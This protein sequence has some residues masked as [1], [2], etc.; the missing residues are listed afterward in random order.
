MNDNKN[1]LLLRGAFVKNPLLVLFLG[2]CPAMAATTGVIPAVGMGCAVLSVMLLSSLVIALIYRAIPNKVKIPA[3]VLITAAFASV[4][5]LLMNAYFPETYRKLGVYMAVAAIDLVII[6]NAETAAEKGVK[7]S[8]L[9][10][11]IT[12]IAFTLAMFVIATLR[13]IL[14]SGCFAGIELPFFNSFN[15]PLLAK[16]PG[17]FFM[18]AILLAV[19]NK[20]FGKSIKGR[21]FACKASCIPTEEIETQGE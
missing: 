4:V 18:F 17:G 14:G 21:S 3:Y 10:S 12:G 6:N 11:V 19:V 16:A 2:A 1:A 5:Q 8:L 20:Y 15:I 7:A 13:E 9:D